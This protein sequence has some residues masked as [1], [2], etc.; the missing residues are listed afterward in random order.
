MIDILPCAVAMYVW[1]QG[2]MYRRKFRCAGSSSPSLRPIDWL[3]RWY[4]HCSVR[5]KICTTVAASWV[6]NW[7]LPFRLLHRLVLLL[8]PRLGTVRG[9]GILR[10][11]AMRHDR[12]H[13]WWSPSQVGI[14]SSFVSLDGREGTWV[15]NIIG[16]HWVMRLHLLLLIGL[17]RGRLSWGIGI[18]WLLWSLRY[19]RN[20]DNRWDAI[21]V[22]HGCFGE[23]TKDKRL[24]GM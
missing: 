21:G 10:E 14:P 4:R 22:G 3:A 6:L 13:H 2:K 12:C 20:V 17:G 1:R 19:R 11:A 7:T 24:C 18:L 23:S 5:D 15:P 16:H 8:L 9:Q